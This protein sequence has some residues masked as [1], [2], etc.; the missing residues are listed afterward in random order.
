MPIAVS[1]TVRTH[2]A[3]GFPGID[4]GTLGLKRLACA[5]A[6]SGANRVGML[7]SRPGSHH[8]RRSEEDLS[9]ETGGLMF[10]VQYQGPTTGGRPIDDGRFNV[11]ERKPL[12]EERLDV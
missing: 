2:G 3:V 11:A 4:R 8:R 9:T 12:S 6:Q 7:D 5:S 1:D 10:F